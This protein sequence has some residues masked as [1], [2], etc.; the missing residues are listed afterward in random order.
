MRDSC[1]KKKSRLVAIQVTSR[2]T[3]TVTSSI[4]SEPKLWLSA[5][6]AIGVF[7]PQRRA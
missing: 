3:P 6:G 4:K 7:F 5:G 2:N 1:R